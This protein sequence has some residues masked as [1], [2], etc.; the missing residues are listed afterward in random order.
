MARWTTFNLSVRGE[1]QWSERYGAEEGGAALCSSINRAVDVS[2]YFLKMHFNNWP[3]NYDLCVS[4]QFDG[5]AQ[6]R[7]LLLFKIQINYNKYSKKMLFCFCLFFSFVFFLTPLKTPGSSHLKMHET[8][9]QMMTFCCKG[10][11]NRCF[12]FVKYNWSVDWLPSYLKL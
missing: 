8:N 10:A 5:A 4:N 9:L 1:E 3:L 6:N 11:L 7:K 12:L 2:H